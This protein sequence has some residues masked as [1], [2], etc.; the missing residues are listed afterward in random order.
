MAECFDAED[1]LSVPDG[2][3]VQVYQPYQFEPLKGSSKRKKPVDFNSS[4][5]DSE[6]CDSVSEHGE[7]AVSGNRP[8]ES[9]VAPVPVGL[10]AWSAGPSLEQLNAIADADVGPPVLP[11]CLYGLYKNN[12]AW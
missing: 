1:V 9:A 12:S 8:R 2:S 4:D 7:G 11:A 6:D 5:S 10:S 3:H